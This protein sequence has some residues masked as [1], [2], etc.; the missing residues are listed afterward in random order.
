[1][2]ISVT[3]IDY[4]EKDKALQIMSR[5][6][7]DDLELAIRK[8]LNQPELDIMTPTP[9]LATNKL[10]AAYL[11]RH[12]RIKVDGKLQKINF[13]G[14]EVEDVALI[15]Y[16]EIAGVKKVKSIEVFDDVIM[17]IHRDQSNLVH[18]TYKSPVKSIR[19]TEEKP[20]EVVMFGD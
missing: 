1:V 4:S 10:V 13:L 9:G 15:C 6:F 11:N 7:I 2:H 5:I 18:I 8:D 17:T 19:L 20:S 3:E 14:Y 16:I 12:L